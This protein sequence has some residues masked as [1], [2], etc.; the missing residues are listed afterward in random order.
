LSKVKKIYLASR[1]IAKLNN[2]IGEGCGEFWRVRLVFEFGTPED[3]DTRKFPFANNSKGYSDKGVVV[4][5][6][7]ELAIGVMV[8]PGNLN[9][10]FTFEVIDF[11]NLPIVFE[12]VLDQRLEGIR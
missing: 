1:L 12:I 9:L 8:L 5:G 2:C 6:I 11:L 4:S 3:I 10:L 7:L